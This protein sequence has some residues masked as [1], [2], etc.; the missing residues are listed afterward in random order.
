MELQTVLKVL[1]VIALTALILA[2]FVLVAA[3]RRLR[4]IRVP[5]NADFF[6]T[7]RAV[8]LSLVVGLDLLDLGLDFL[9]TPFVWFIL[10]RLKLQALR[11]VASFEALVPFT[12]PVPTLTL[13]WFAARMFNLGRPYDPNIIET[14]RIGPNEY[15]S[16]PEP[17]GRGGSRG[18]R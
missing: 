3:F 7:I 16:R 2:A 8:P 17:R 9:S 12:G 15:V 13:A 4:R 1:G 6:T 18:H 10:D 14:E 11:N 5:P